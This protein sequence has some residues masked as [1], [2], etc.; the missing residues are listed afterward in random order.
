MRKDRAM[1]QC[2]RDSFAGI[3]EGW[4]R[5]IAIRRQLAFTGAAVIILLA[6]GAPFGWTVA[7]L[8]LLMIGLAAELL[9]AAVEALL[10]RLH[11]GWDSAIGAAKDMASAA[12]FLVNTAAVVTTLCAVVVS[13]A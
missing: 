6:V 13:L 8:A 5:D 2:L 1:F 4:R 12:A 3:R 10:D 11:P 9:N 7:S